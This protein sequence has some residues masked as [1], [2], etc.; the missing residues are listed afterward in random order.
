MK[1]LFTFLTLLV[2]AYTAKSQKRIESF[3]ASL[4]LSEY[5]IIYFKSND[6]SGISQSRDTVNAY[7]GEAALRMEYNI[8]SL[9]EWG[10]S[11]TLAMELPADRAYWDFSGYDRISFNLYN[12]AKSSEAGRASLRFMLHDKSEFG[13]TENKREFWWSFLW[14]FDLEP[15]W[16]TITLPLKD[17]GLAAESDPGSGFWLTGSAGHMGNET[18]DLDKIS[19]IGFSIAVNGPADSADISGTFLV[20]NL[21]LIGERPSPFGQEL[22][23][24]FDE[25]FEVKGYNVLDFIGSDSSSITRSQDSMDVYEATASLRLEYSV[26][27]EET[28]GGTV[29]VNFSNP[30]VEFWD[31]SEYDSIGFN[32]Y[33]KVKSSSVG[34]SHL[35]F[36]LFDGSEP[37]ETEFWYSFLW[38]LDLEPGWN[39]I[40]LPLKD[41]GATAQSKPGSGFWL[42]GWALEMG[43][44]TL[45][46]DKITAVGFEIAVAGPADYEDITGTILIDNLHLVN[47]KTTTAINTLESRPKTFTLE[48]NYPNPFSQE[49]MIPFYV[50]DRE[51]VKLS[52]YDISGQEV[53][54]LMDE[55]V[56]AGNHNILFH[57]ESI[58][59]GI[60]FYH[61]QAGDYSD[62]RRLLIS[63]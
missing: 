35:R 7:E 14:P 18:L 24:S 57:A 21:M 2:F 13:P 12:E 50:A 49:T 62:T 8:R 20:D 52:I 46:L 40:T 39:T 55:V 28:W 34:R 33:N 54:V 10:S 19:G 23:E 48:Q 15:G 26:N 44:E 51:R 63:R 41:V 47:K 25:A 53:D 5:E 22:I 9:E 30:E 17:L 4:E 6:S 3:D 32:F 31:F 1:K 27:S 16:N 38:P 43:N 29:G 45:D 60:Y 42:T 58:P 37:G 56:P 36:N 59:A 61:L 11:T